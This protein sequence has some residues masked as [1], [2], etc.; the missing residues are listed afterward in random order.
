MKA[1]YL[2]DMM[3]DISA[4]FDSESGH[5]EAPNSV[6]SHVSRFWEPRMRR[7]IIAYLQKSGG[8]G[9]SDVSLKAVALLAEQAAGK[10]PAA[11]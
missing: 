3:N 2:V 8:T 10:S 11:H 6:A 4:F 1:Q 5:A 9:L 7:E